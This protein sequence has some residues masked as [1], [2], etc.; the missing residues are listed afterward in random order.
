MTHVIGW[1]ILVAAFAFLVFAIRHGLG[2]KREDRPD[3]DPMGPT[4]WWWLG[5]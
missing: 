4:G 3:H 1:L 5:N 2:T